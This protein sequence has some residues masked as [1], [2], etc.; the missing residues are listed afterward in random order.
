MRKLV[1]V[2]TA[3]AM[4]VASGCS[5]RLGD[6]TILSTKNVALNPSPERRSVE[7]KHCANLLLGLIPLGSFTPNIEEAIDNA[8]RHVPEGNVMTN[9]VIYQEPLFLLIFSRNCFR[10]K[11]D[12]GVES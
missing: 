11:G 3:L 6:F 5:T 4:L 8:F 10:V 2:I 7:G 9:A 12:I 1:I